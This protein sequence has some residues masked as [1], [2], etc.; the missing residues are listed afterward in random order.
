MESFFTC[1]DRS[2]SIF[3]SRGLR[4]AAEVLDYDPDCSFFKNA[5][6]LTPQVVQEAPEMIGLLKKRGVVKSASLG[7]LELELSDD[8]LFTESEMISCLQWVLKAEAAIGDIAESFLRIARFQHSSS[9]RRVELRQIRT[10][11]VPEG[12]EF[13]R[14]IQSGEYLPDHTLPYEVSKG[15]QVDQLM[16]L[17]Q[18]FGW[19]KLGVIEW[20]ENLTSLLS[21]SEQGSITGTIFAE[22]CFDILALSWSG[23]GE[24]D[25]ERIKELLKDLECIPTQEGMKRPQEAY[26]W[27]CSV[28]GLPTVTIPE[29]EVVRLIVSSFIRCNPF[30]APDYFLAPVFRTE[31]Q[32][33]VSCVI[34]YCM[35][36]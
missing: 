2:L 15:L 25:K 29:S 21:S 24:V 32:C 30:H 33:R 17:I 6:M 35:Q 8:R 34:G 13:S 7:D 1:S 20:L 16:Q 22:L 11:L 3:S 14:L 10:V 36:S 4:P 31:S 19:K 5:P 23:L 9:S 12:P 26:L 18:L 28:L 27:G